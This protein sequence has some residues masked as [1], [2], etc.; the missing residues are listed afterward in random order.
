MRQTVEQNMKI[1]NA[2]F[3]YWCEKFIS[4]VDRNDEAGIKEANE[5]IKEEQMILEELEELLQRN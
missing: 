2:V 5:R 4:A 1:H 3:R